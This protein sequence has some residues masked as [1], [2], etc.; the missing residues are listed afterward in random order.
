M[1]GILQVYRNCNRVTRRKMKPKVAKEFA[2]RSKEYH[3]YDY[4]MS[5]L[6]LEE[7]NKSVEKSMEAHQVAMQVLPYDLYKE[8]YDGPQECPFSGDLRYYDP[9]RMYF[10]QMMRI[11]PKEISTRNFCTLHT[12]RHMLKLQKT[13]KVKEDMKEFEKDVEGQALVEN[14]EQDRKDYGLDDVQRESMEYGENVIRSII[15]NGNLLEKV[16]DIKMDSGDEDSFSEPEDHDLTVPAPSKMAQ[17]VADAKALN[18][19]DK[20]ASSI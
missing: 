4:H 9:G 13:T 18:N 19:A 6:E 15:N 17:P 10:E 5:R 16:P 1:L 12:V 20:L 2:K 11:Y 7:G 3:D 14:D 8:M